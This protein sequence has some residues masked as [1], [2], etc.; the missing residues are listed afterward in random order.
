MTLSSETIVLGK[1]KKAYLIINELLFDSENFLAVEL[2]KNKTYSGLKTA[3]KAF[4]LVFGGILQIGL[5]TLCVFMAVKYIRSLHFAIIL[6]ECPFFG[7][8]LLIFANDLVLL[9]WTLKYT[10]MIFK[11]NLLILTILMIPMIG[12]EVLV[13]LISV[14]TLKRYRAPMIPV[15]GSV[16]ASL[17]WLGLVMR[18]YSLVYL[19]I[20]PQIFVVC[21]DLCCLI[22]GMVFTKKM[23]AGISGW[24]L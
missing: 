10:R 13:L 4:F 11:T 21:L 17:I 23:T 19:T 3:G 24:S 16:V 20:I 1:I 2:I 9:I 15:L 22:K 7:C 14:R 12:F 18:D 6:I 5:T 8:I